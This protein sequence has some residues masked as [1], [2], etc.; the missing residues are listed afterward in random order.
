MDNKTKVCLRVPSSELRLY[1]D[2][3]AE[4]GLKYLVVLPYKS[5]E[6]LDISKKMPCDGDYGIFDQFILIIVT[7]ACSDKILSY[8]GR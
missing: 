8:I 3:H 7:Q 1:L 2:K 5:L 6:S 4:S